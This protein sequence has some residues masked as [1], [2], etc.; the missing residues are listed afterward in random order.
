MMEN[1]SHLSN[2]NR[3]VIKIGSALLVDEVGQIRY[4]WLES[5]GLD[6]SNLRKNGKDVIVV[7]SGSIAVGRKNLGFKPEDVLHLQEKQAAAATGQLKL[8]HAYKEV[9]AQHKIVISQ[10]LL[11]F[12]NT[13]NR[14]QYLNARNALKTLVRLGAVPLIN[15]ND[16]VAI[17]EIK[18]GDNDRLAARVAQMVDADT[19]ILL[20]DIDGLYTADPT[21]NLDA[22]FIPEVTEITPNIEAMAGGAGSL[23]GSGGMRTKIIAAKICMNAGCRMV[24]LKG[25]E[26]S[27]IERLVNGEKSTWF[28]PSSTP[29]NAR[30]QWILGALGSTGTIFVDQG[31]EAALYRGK[32]LLS[33]GVSD[34][35]GDFA[36][37]DAVD[38]KNQ[39]G[40]HIAKGLVAY[41]SID[42]FK[43]MRRKSAEIE[44][45][46]GYKG[47]DELVH[48]D[49]LVMLNNCQANK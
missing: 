30:K 49:D 21:K 36:I 38:I 14:Q 28:V 33:A 5:L 48:R 15:E 31:A 13:E 39:D 25:H 23:V 3:I 34:V 46:L 19:L 43:I 35:E 41:S 1:I 45:I 42:A 26:K 7:S 47:K 20:S 2:A 12:N 8:A 22:K 37:G 29:M 16:A 27:P 6:I 9:M 4:D 40:E 24:I 10:I 32:S 18:F 17:E 11:A 44:K